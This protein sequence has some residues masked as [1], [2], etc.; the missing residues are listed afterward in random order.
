MIQRLLLARELSVK[1]YM[2]NAIP[3]LILF[4]YQ[5]VVAVLIAGVAVYLKHKRT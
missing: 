5:S 4:L 2:N 3:L 1:R